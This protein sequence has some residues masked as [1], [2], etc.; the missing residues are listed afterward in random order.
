MAT[1]LVS[2][3]KGVCKECEEDYDKGD[4]I[5]YDPSPKDIGKK[6]IVCVNY[7]CYKDQGGKEVKLTGDKSTNADDFT[8]VFPK[9]EDAIMQK[10]EY[11][12]PIVDTILLHVD[13]KVRDMYPNLSP[14]SSVF[15]TIRYALAVLYKDLYIARNFKN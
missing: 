13:R 3:F 1:R 14:S 6:A 9:G 5:F 15:G 2:N 11:I 4:M 7:E 12:D 8:F 10:L